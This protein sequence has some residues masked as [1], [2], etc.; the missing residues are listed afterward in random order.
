MASAALAHPDKAHY[1]GEDAWFHSPVSGTIG[2]F[3][4]KKSFFLFFFFNSLLSFVFSDKRFCIADVVSLSPFFLQSA[5]KNN[6]LGEK[7]KK[8]KKEKKKSEVSLTS[9]FFRREDKKNS[10]N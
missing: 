5:S 2:E 3:S 10:Q 9:S 8:K 7:E 1:G 6:V 4:R